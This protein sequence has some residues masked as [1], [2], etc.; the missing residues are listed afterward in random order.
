MNS[1]KILTHISGL[2]AFA[3][4]A[5]IIFHLDTKFHAHGFNGYLGV[6]IFFTISGYLLL[7]SWLNTPDFSLKSFLQKKIFRLYLPIC[8][9]L[10]IT[11][12]F[13]C[14]VPS[15]ISETVA[16]TAVFTLLGTSNIW[17][18]LQSGGY[19]DRGTALNPLFH[20][21]YVSALLQMFLICGV[22][23]GVLHRISKKRTKTFFLFVC[24]VSFIW[25]NIGLIPYIFDRIF[26][27]FCAVCQQ[28][29]PNYY[30]TLPRLWQFLAGGVVLMLP[31]LRRTVTSFMATA[32]GWMFILLPMANFIPNAFLSISV[33]IGT[34]LVIRY[35][36]QCLIGQWMSNSSLTTIG[37]YSFSLYL[38]H[39]PVFVFSRSF[40]S[41]VGISFGVNLGISLM[42]EGL[43]IT[44]VI[45][46]SI[47]FYHYFEKRQISLHA[48]AI[49][50]GLLLLLNG[51]LIYK[52][53]TITSW[54]KRAN[55]VEA[56]HYHE[57]TPLH[58]HPLLA[59]MPREHLP[60][61][62]EVLK[63]YS[64]DYFNSEKTEN[65]FVIGNEK[66]S[67]NFILLGDSHAAAIFPGLNHALKNEAISGVY[68][69]TR[70]VPFFSKSPAFAQSEGCLK[71]SDYMQKREE[72]LLKWL[73]AHEEITTVFMA[74]RWSLYYAAQGIKKDDTDTN[75]EKRIEDY[76][77]R[78]MCEKFRKIGKK[79]VILTEVPCMNYSE[80]LTYYKQ[81]L[82]LGFEPIDIQMHINEAEYSE[83][84][85][86]FL[87]MLQKLEKEGLCH[88]IHAEEG[89]RQQKMFVGITA[90]T[91]LYY[92]GNH[93]NSKGARIICD[94]LKEEI[95][96]ELSTE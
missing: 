67:P 1:K 69:L 38:C 45:L 89:I 80:P 33:V 44:G 39:V 10:L 50:Y 42:Q 46:S 41:F 54:Q 22:S 11:L 90:G 96:R 51:I 52:D 6:E 8:Y 75:G 2:R 28:H 34:I 29:T 85:K 57:F 61:W 37:K 32:A 17:F 3:I 49:L 88:L 56:D 14:F 59:N 86:Q 12:P 63:L 74:A 93:V 53:G 19:F 79:I 9:L 76:E 95:V 65:I 13:C 84:C 26:P 62:K 7:K 25:G 23:Y 47:L 72:A 16:K 64:T 58:H 18:K 30:D 48:A 21:W 92:D 55:A 77:L 70:Y 66:L 83:Q 36:P 91:L 15:D 87:P 71:E 78:S 81:Q 60:L 4:L 40:F 73:K 5:V 24:L 82:I 43:L 94:K 20:T 35:A 27:E 68:I 31:E